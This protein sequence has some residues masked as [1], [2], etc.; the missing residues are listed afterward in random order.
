MTCPVCKTPYEKKRSTVLSVYVYSKRCK[1]KRA[2]M[3]PKPKTY[4]I[5]DCWRDEVM[6]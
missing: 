3:K 1:C 4:D 2:T 5:R 6:R